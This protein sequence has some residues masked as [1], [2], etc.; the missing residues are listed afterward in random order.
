[1]YSTISFE[2]Q[3]TRQHKTNK[4]EINNEKSQVQNKKNICNKFTPNKTIIKISTGN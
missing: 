1:M 4:H 2:D 3:F